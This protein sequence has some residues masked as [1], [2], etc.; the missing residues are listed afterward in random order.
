MHHDWDD[1]FLKKRKAGGFVNL[2]KAAKRDA[3]KAGQQ[4]SSEAFE[5]L[6]STLQLVSKC[7]HVNSKTATG[8]SVGYG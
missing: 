8:F 4:T 6:V 2:L 7:A 5:F 3:F 1:A